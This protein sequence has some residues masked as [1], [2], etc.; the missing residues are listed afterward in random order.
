MGTQEKKPEDAT[1][2]RP[3]GAVLAMVGRIV[4]PLAKS[5]IKGC[6][7]VGE[8]VQAATGG[9]RAIYLEA[10]AQ[11]RGEAPAAPSS[12]R[13][14]GVTAGET[15]VV[16]PGRPR[17]SRARRTTGSAPRSRAARSAAAEPASPAAEPK[18]PRK[19]A[20]RASASDSRK[21]AVQNPQDV[22]EAVSEPP[23]VDAPSREESA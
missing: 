2:R 8:S 13:T 16:A 12:E 4:R 6:L 11:A 17:P 20:P 9:L 10:A 14:S 23:P 5:A 15:G 19:R 1:G 3:V 7:A 22:S 18:P 21:V